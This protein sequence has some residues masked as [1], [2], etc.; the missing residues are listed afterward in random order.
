MPD[1][2]RAQARTFADHELR[3]PAALVEHRRYHDFLLCRLEG[4]YFDTE[5]L[6]SWQ[7]GLPDFAK[8]PCVMSATIN[9]L[10]RDRVDVDACRLG[11]CSAPKD[12]N[13]SEKLLR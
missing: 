6:A 1:I 8:S 9:L 11:A 5:H 4:Q 2:P 3:G 12:D 7:S 13:H 10:R